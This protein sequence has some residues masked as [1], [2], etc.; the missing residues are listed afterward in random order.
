VEPNAVHRPLVARFRVFA[1][2]LLALAATRP[3][4]AQFEFSGSWNYVGS[5]DFS[6]DSL[7]VDYMG[8]PLTEEGRARALT[9]SESQL[10]MPEHQCEA[11]PPT[12]LATGGFAL[13]VTKQTEAIKGATVSYTIA[14]WSDRVP[15]VIWMDGRPHPSKYALHTR[16]GFTTGKWEGSTLVTY[17]THMKTGNLR[18]TGPPISDEATMTTRYFRHGNIL[19]MLSVIEDPYYLTEPV[20]WTKSFKLAEAEVPSQV[21]ACITTYEGATPGEVPHY[22]PETNPFVDEMSKKYN[23]PRDVVLGYPKTLY[24]EYRQEM[25]K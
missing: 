6:N 15:T 14:A 16:S 19:T 7:P 22:S 20:V 10:S 21:I 9:Y 23:L 8:L 18:K 17:T 24:P 1:L 12:Y 3:A 25:K 11:W 2:V 4:A 13:L 5:E